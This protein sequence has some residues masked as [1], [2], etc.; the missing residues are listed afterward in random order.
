[1]VRGTSVQPLHAVMVNGMHPANRGFS[2]SP[3]RKPQ[4]PPV[5][6]KPLVL[7]PQVYAYQQQ[8]LNPL[9][10][11][12]ASSE[13]RKNFLWQS[14]A[15]RLQP[16]LPPDKLHYMKRLSEDLTS[17]DLFSMEE[18]NRMLSDNQFLEDQVQELI[19]L[20]DQGH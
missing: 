2:A 12:G 8:Q 11:P 5:M 3:T 13:Q 15:H 14:I 20:Y 7:P 4:M 6:P 9:N 10:N 16:L 1:M 19:V 18:M 17:L